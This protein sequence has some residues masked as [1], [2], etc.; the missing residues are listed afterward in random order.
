MI[1]I[2]TEQCSKFFPIFFMILSVYGCDAENNFSAQK[3]YQQKVDKCRVELAGYRKIP[4]IG[5]GYLDLEILGKSSAGVRYE[6]GQCG[7][8]TVEVSFWWT[9]EEVIPDSPKFMANKQRDLPEVWRLYKVVA[10]LGNRTKSV[11]CERNSKI[12]ECPGF[13]AAD[14]GG[15]QVSS[16]PKKFIVKLKNYPGLELWLPVEPP[17]KK[18]SSRI[19]NFIIS[20]W[21]RSD[22][23]PRSINCWGLNRL[24]PEYQE[25]N[26]SAKDLALLSRGELENIN[27]AGRLQHGVACQVEFWDFDF[28]G[29]AGR[30]S[31]STESLASAPQALKSINLYLK[32]AIIKGK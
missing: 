5:G 19:N 21:R 16:W 18:N 7:T 27:L 32:N 1:R 11:A 8:D 9:G 13:K 15:Y 3:K 12:S 28:D 22:G 4:I 31:F 17:N 20:D 29:G 24:G 14:Q 25:T 2:Y 23:S 26:L 6:D 10:S 30:V